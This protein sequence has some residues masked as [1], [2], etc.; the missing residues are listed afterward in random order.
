MFLNDTP[1]RAHGFRFNMGLGEAVDIPTYGDTG[2]GG[3]D[4]TFIDIP[5]PF[6]TGGDMGGALNPYQ[7]PV[8]TTT[9]GGGTFNTPAPVNNPNTSLA[10]TNA[11]TGFGS[12]LAKVFGPQ[13]SLIPGTGLVYNPQTGQMVSAVGQ[14]AGTVSGSIMMPLIIGVVLLM[15][16]KK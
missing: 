16:L 13:P 1:Q 9:Y 11:V 6:S 15:M 4:N 5:T 10:V 7:P 12:W 8:V 3:G 2:G 14:T